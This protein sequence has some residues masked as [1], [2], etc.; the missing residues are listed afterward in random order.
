MRVALWLARIHGGSPLQ[1]GL[2]R[3]LCAL[4]HHVEEYRPGVGYDLVLVH[5]IVTHTRDYSYPPFPDG[6][7]PIAFIDAAEFG[8]KTR[9]PEN[10]W[11]WANSFTPS[12][13][14]HDTKNTHEQ[15]RLKTWLEGRSFPY[16]L[17]EMHKAVDYP[18]GYH[19]I[20]YPLYWLS[21]YDGTPNR[22][23]YLS[24]QLELFC[25]WGHSHPWRQHI[26]EALRGAHRKA[27]IGNRWS[28]ENKPQAHYFDRMR[29]AKCTV[30]FDGYG[31]SSFRLQEG[32]CR[33]VVLA[34]PLTIQ[35]RR[36]LVD[37]E[38]A[39]FYDVESN[40]EEFVN[41]NV[42]DRLRYLLEN[43]EHAF[44][45]YQRGFEH[46]HAYW[47]EKAVAAYVLEV[48]E[49]HDWSRPTALEV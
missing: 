25:W 46:V 20:D 9:L 27:E 5:N 29:A 15:W 39:F 40:G 11:A 16:F 44:Q 2:A 26:E 38:T 41:T 7:T 4:G 13:M 43:P 6:N 32:L 36:P 8:W 22:E 45:V 48:V 23:E 47:T 49:Q 24:R 3:G 31:S 34:G 33:T 19:P 35:M 30:S 17:R 14:G 37:G 21:S 42:A 1:G 18:A 28:D 12:A 10:V